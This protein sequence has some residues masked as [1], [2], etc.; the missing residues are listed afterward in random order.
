M[1]VGIAASLLKGVDYE[2]AILLSLLLRRSGAPG[3]RS[4]GGRRSSTPGSRRPGS[5]PS[6]G[7]SPPRSGSASS[8]SSTS[9]TRT[10]SGGSSSCTARRRGSCGRRRRGDDGAAVRGRAPAA[11]RPAR[12][13]RADATTTSLTPG[14]AIAAQAATSPNLVYLRDKALLFNE[15]RS[16]RFVMYGVQ[17]RTWV[18]HGRSGRA[19]RGRAAPD[20]RVPRALRR[21]RRRAGVLRD[22]QRRTCIATPTSA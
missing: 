16:P 19:R 6:P 1:V 22:R 5:P 15:A 13:A 18:A 14:A 12:G 7:R 21:L 2:E 17:G 4:T 11:A 3:R 9:S 8:P 10:S 20:P